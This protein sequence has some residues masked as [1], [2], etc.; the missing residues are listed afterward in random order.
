MLDIGADGIIVPNVTGPAEV[1]Q[2]VSFA[3]Y[4][5]RGVRGVGGERATYWGMKLEE[6][7]RTADDETMVIPMME[8]VAAGEAIEEILDVRGVDGVFFGPADYSASGGY[9]GQWEGPG[10]A[11][12][13]LEIKDAIV[14]R[15]IACGMMTTGIEDAVRRK[16]QG[17]R[18]LA[19]GADT[20]LLIR[21]IREMT[22]VL[23][24]D[25]PQP[26]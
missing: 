22:N 3:K 7:T 18:M 13:L 15:G 6:Y 23:T 8:T 25:A 1:E 26:G 24:D 2:A 9:L 14:A 5:P 10:V 16:Q 12:R 4:P 11:E 21:S 20:G 19:L 17:F